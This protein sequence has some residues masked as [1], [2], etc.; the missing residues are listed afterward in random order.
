MYF[1]HRSHR[2]QPPVHLT[3][4]AGEGVAYIGML[5]TVCL[6]FQ[7]LPV[8]EALMAADRPT[9]TTTTPQ[10]AQSDIR[11]VLAKEAK[12]S[13]PPPKQPEDVSLHIQSQQSGSEA[14]Y[15]SVSDRTVAGQGTG[16]GGGRRVGVSWTSLVLAVG[17]SQS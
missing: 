12:A 9:D 1:A 5:A 2:S 17:T 3:V 4:C 16:R 8:S 15:R 14:V 13:P 6:Y 11:S 10:S 7:Q